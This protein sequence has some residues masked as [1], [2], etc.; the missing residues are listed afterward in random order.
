MKKVIK[1]LCLTALVILSSCATRKD[2]IYLQDMNEL[3]EYPVVQK[4]EAVIHRDDKL[5]I[6][7]NSKN[8][9]LALPFNIPGSNGN[10]SIDVDGSITSTGGNTPTDGK[11][12]RGYLVDVNG[13]IDF[14]ILGKLM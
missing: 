13:D 2:F 3:Q 11:N 10:F 5:S 14:P 8:P 6:I 9:E 1:F 7:V 4:Y 12:P